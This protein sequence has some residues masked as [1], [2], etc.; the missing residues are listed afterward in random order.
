MY[1]AIRLIRPTALAASLISLGFV[2]CAHVP[3]PVGPDYKRPEI[4]PPTEF[5]SQERPQETASLADLPWWKVFND[6]ALQQLIMEALKGNYDIQVAVAR[7]G[8]A[9]AA[10]TVVRADLYP[11]VS[12]NAF[13]GREQSFFPFPGENGNVLF[14]AFGTTVNAA[15]ELDVWGRIRRASESARANLYAQE[16]VRQAVRLSLV[17]DVA[18]NYFSLIELDRQLAI[19]RESAETYSQTLDLFT[20]RFQAGRDSKLAVTRA[21]AAYDSSKAT[22]AR[23]N[24]AIAQQENVIC[25]LLGSYPRAIDRGQQL[26]AQVTPETPLGQSTELLRRRPDIQQ[27]ENGMV[28]ANADVGV[29]IANFYP[30]IG[31][32]A[33]FGGQAP[34]IENVFD[35]NFKVWNI[36]AGLSGPIFQG[37]R[38]RATYEQRKAFWDE[39]IAEY[40]KTV[41]TAFRETSDAIIAQQTL[42]SQR[43]ALQSEIEALKQSAQ[44]ALER[45]D[46]G[47]ST[48]F[49]VLEAQQQLFP[50]EDALAQTQRDQLV[51][52]V[53][54]YKALG[55]GWSLNDADWEKPQ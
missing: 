49:E 22:I 24:R 15:W 27:A 20:R 30:R 54:L 34:K 28:A 21:Q 17:A 13:A 33:L 45:Y 39:T 8:Q 4:A 32:S 16:N 5:R 37:G 18:A 10:V 43:D 9:R 35:S 19:A 46:G 2:G 50:A 1:A 41:I 25:V 29:A 7:I 47:R 3:K 23:V 51:A 40:R 14:N 42:V 48:Y 55:G 38:L 52:V 31:L 6:K 53:N 26:T 12:Y 44:F 36:A 11:Q